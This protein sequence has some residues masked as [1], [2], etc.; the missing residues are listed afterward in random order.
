MTAIAAAERDILDLE[1]AGSRLLRARAVRDVRGPVLTGTE[2]DHD[3]VSRPRQVADIQIANGCCP[4]LDDRLSAT[5]GRASSRDVVV[6]L[7]EHPREERPAEQA[8]ERTVTLPRAVLVAAGCDVNI[9][10]H[11]VLEQSRPLVGVLL[12]VV[13]EIW[14]RVPAMNPSEVEAARG[15]LVALTAGAIRAGTGLVAPRHGLPALRA[16]IEKWI[17]ENLRRGPIHV[18]SLADAHCVSARTI[19]RAF[20]LT[21]DTMTG[22]LR[23]R[24]LAAVREELVHTDLTIAAIAQRWSYYDPSHLGREFRRHFGVSPR[25]YRESHQC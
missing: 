16:Q 23:A 18:E 24:R 1:P 11:L 19:H 9:S 3:E 20:S 7:S 10:S 6:V 12:M 8:S 25:D 5:D 21:G 17:D 2:Q 14:S 22:V 4:L 15:A 13:D